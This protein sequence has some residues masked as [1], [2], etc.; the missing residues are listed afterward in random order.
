MIPVRLE[1]KN[2]LAYR[3]PQPLRLDD[4]HLACLTGVNGAGKS[5]LLDA[6][7]WA[8]WGK[9]R[10][11]DNNLIHLGQKEM[12]VILDF[13]HEGQKYRVARYRQRRG[14]GGTSK[15]ELFIFDGDNSLQEIHEA[16]I[17]ATQN[18]INQ[19]LRLDYDTFINSA[20]LQ[21]G[22]ADSFTVKRPAER[23]QI[24]ANI[25]G[26]EAW[27]DYETAAKD[28][29]AEHEK[30]VQA[31]AYRIEDIDKELV[32]EPQYRQD[33]ADAQTAHE[34]A[35]R[36]VA[37]A[38]DL[39]ETLQGAPAELKAAK[40]KHDNN[41][42]RR[43]EHERDLS[44]VRQ[45]MQRQTDDI[46]RYEDIIAQ[47]DDIQAGYDAL[48]E[49]R[50]T[51]EALTQ[52]MRELTDI[53]QRLNVLEK[54]L[55]NERT[56][57]QSERDNLLKEIAK[58]DKQTQSADPAQLDALREQQADLEAQI[59]QREAAQ[60]TLNALKEEK[61]GREA[62]N[63]QLKITMDE[64]KERIDT[65]EAVEG[66]E[67]PLCGQALTDDHRATMLES[68]QTE[69]TSQGD[70]YRAN[71]DRVKAIEA[72]IKTL[73]ADI[74]RLG[75]AAA[76][77]PRVQKQIG[78]LEQQVKAADEAR[79][80][81]AEAETR[82][83]DVSA[84]LENDDY[85]HDLRVQIDAVQA[86]RDAVGYDK[87]EHAEQ[88][89]RLNEFRRYEQLHTQLSIAAESLPTLREAYDGNQERETRLLAAIETLDA[90]QVA[91]QGE[92]VELEAR[93]TEYNK[94]KAEVANLRT[95]ASHAREKV[96]TAE[97]ALNALQAKREQREQYESK[98]KEEAEQVSIYKELREAFGKKG[99]PAMI[100]ESAIPEIEQIANDLLGRMTDGRMSVRF[101]TQREK[102]TGGVSET[103]DIS[104]SDELGTRNYEMYSGGESFRINFAIR[105]ALS[106]LL[107][108]RAGAH[109]E[110][111]F[112]DEGF[113]TQDAD[114]RT[115]LVE[116]IN[117]VKDEFDL[118]LIITHIDEL[119]DAFPVH[120]H[121]EK[122]RDG[123][124]ITLR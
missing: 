67:C 65:L 35:E 81:L 92:I 76:Q 38:E 58:L 5:S 89:N 60:E 50:S 82:L 106:K 75:D 57:L 24:L 83:S 53:D 96:I 73:T 110:T 123:S 124:H 56:R 113:G 88:K 112:I 66:A 119:K 39:L 99:V 122:G 42:R 36:D 90:E 14:N 3:S 114:G 19:L 30:T 18:R 46:T 31:L 104:I 62:T 16:S 6:M 26:I 22:Q 54:E 109:L 78:T 44:A 12:S 55:S 79:R 107:A 120:I 121:V 74:K 41:Q 52:K 70:T 95:V 37:A 9:A 21:Q 32:R 93:V 72:D 117:A 97:Q 101:D 43:K 40:D 49:A 77:L 51:S 13:L 2:F 100:I 85:A 10:S 17:N 47:Q 115:K 7:T 91:L 23:K 45:N 71:R 84:M 118:I 34:A 86:E 116:A 98:R 87:A 64:L 80:Q 103:L 11:K 15:L 102:V 33:L 68:L 27:E 48:Q 29:A 59:S 63:K 94:R 111:L 69:G 1:I 4:V 20:F 28:K 61:S 108:R 105:V 8:L 25:L